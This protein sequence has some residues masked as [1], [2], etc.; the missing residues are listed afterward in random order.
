[1]LMLPVLNPF[2][3]QE[4]EWK[5]NFIVDLLPTATDPKFIAPKDGGHSGGGITVVGAE[6]VA[7]VGAT[8]DEVGAEVEAWAEVEVTVGTDVVTR[9]VGSGVVVVT[10]SDV[11]GG[12]VVVL[13]AMVEPTAGA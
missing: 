3:W 1:M 10:S 9:V 4:G 12:G 8:V 13:G 2:G 5:E 11:T 7:E 6:V